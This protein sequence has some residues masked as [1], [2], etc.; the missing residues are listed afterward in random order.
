M[1]VPVA[2]CVAL[3]LA[4]ILPWVA[5]DRLFERV[6]PFTTVGRVRTLLEQSRAVVH[7]AGSDAAVFPLLAD[8]GRVLAQAHVRGPLWRPGTEWLVKRVVPPV[9]VPADAAMVAIGQVDEVRFQADE[10]SKVALSL[11]TAGPPYAA[12]ARHYAARAE[13]AARRKPVDDPGTT[14]EDLVRLAHVR[15][16]LEDH[17]A[18]LGLAEEA[19]RLM[20]EEI[21]KR[22]LELEGLNRP[23]IG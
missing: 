5:A 20:S 8:W 12:P 3:V 22:F 2:V 16:E 19:T 23:P 9:T 21:E 11:A 10:L 4:L 15:N 14:M 17:D 13:Q 6:L 1:T 7:E 18:A